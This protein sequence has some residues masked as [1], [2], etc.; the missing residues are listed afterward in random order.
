M[1][2]KERQEKFDEKK[3]FDSIEVNRDTCGTYKQ[4]ISVINQLTF[5]V[6]QHIIRVRKRKKIV[7]DKFYEK[8]RTYSKLSF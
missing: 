7:G 8:S 1:T 5:L 3:W 2:N 4:W 6:Q